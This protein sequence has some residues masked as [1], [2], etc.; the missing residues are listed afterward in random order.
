MKISSKTDVGLVR[1]SNQDACD[2][3]PLPG[4]DAAWAVVCDGMGGA[5]GGNVA[6]EMAVQ[7]ISKQITASYRENMSGNSI[8]LLMQ[9]AIYNANVAIYDR[10]LMERSLQGMGT[11]V[12]LAVIADGCV[13]V[14]HAGDSRAYLI[15]SGRI[16][17]I[18]TDHSMVQEMVK[19]GEITE[20]QARGHPRKNII[21]RA[22]G[23]DAQVE[24]DYN[25][26]PFEGE[27]ILLVCTDGLSNYLESEAICKLASQMDVD[28]LAQE[29]VSRAK[30]LGGSDNITVVIISREI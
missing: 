29:L 22:L 26:F 5:N 28:S 18:T 1:R 19:R 17:Q 21:T 12:V 25:E 24:V 6:S 10:S 13:H 9:T 20:K 23:V 2:S 30:A 16:L 15:S 4:R 14:A 7:I 8:K 3:G 11:T 27:D